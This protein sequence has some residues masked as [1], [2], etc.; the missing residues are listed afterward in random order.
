MV[1]KA[2]AS[3]NAFSGLVCLVPASVAQSLRQGRGPVVPPSSANF[4]F[5]ALR[6]VRAY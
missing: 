3:V 4:V 5:R 6:P 1:P 2:N